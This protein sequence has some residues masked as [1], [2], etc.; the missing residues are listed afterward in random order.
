MEEWKK[1]LIFFSKSPADRLKRC[2]IDLEDYENPSV[3]KYIFSLSRYIDSSISAKCL[4]AKSSNFAF[5]LIIKDSK[6]FFGI[7]KL[8]SYVCRS[9]YFRF[10]RQ[11]IYSVKSEIF[12]YIFS[13]KNFIDFIIST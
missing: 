8:F 1:I 3:L 6:K 11:K 7:R 10:F 9:F 12:K 4:K 2:R 13:L 5:Y